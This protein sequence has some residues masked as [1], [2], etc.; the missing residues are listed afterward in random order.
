MVIFRSQKGSAS[1]TFRK[2]CTIVDHG[3]GYSDVTPCILSRVF[4]LMIE[5]ENLSKLRHIYMRQ[6]DVKFDYPCVHGLDSSGS[7]HK[8]E[9]GFCENGAETS[10]YVK[11]RR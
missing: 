2:R 11:P 1:R 10:V 9:A 4:T 7:G 5:K 8:K 6:H 3:V